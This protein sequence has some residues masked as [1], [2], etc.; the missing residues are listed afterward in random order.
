MV[1][2]SCPETGSKGMTV[3]LHLNSERSQPFIPVIGL[4]PII[5]YLFKV[6][7]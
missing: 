4:N 2:M 6:K 1:N 7:A 5:T 3:I